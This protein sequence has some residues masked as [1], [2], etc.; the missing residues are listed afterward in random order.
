MYA[1]MNVFRYVACGD[2]S[3]SEPTRFRWV[4]SHIHL[5]EIHR[6]GNTD[7]LEGMKMLGAVEIVDILDEKF[8]ST[9]NVVLRPYLDPY[10]RYGQHLQAI[11]GFE[12]VNDHS[13]EYLIRIFGADNFSELGKTPDQIREEIDILTAEID[14]ETRAALLDKTEAISEEMKSHINTHLKDIMP[15]DKTRKTI[16]ITSEIRKGIEVSISPIDEVWKFISPCMQGVTKN[17]FF[18]FEANPHIDGVQHTQHGAISGAHA[19]LNLLGINPDQGLA[20][21]E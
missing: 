3:I 12:E 10:I 11:S 2:I 15:I 7:A 8:Q 14:S 20:K 21:R 17:Q 9:G 6:N 1:D 18:G 16:G 13:I 4:Y 19:I 5:D